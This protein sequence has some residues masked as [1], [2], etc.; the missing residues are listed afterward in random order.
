MLPLCSPCAVPCSPLVPLLPTGFFYLQTIFFFTYMIPSCGLLVFH[1]LGNGTGWVSD[2]RRRREE[3][4][5]SC[6]HPCASLVLF[7][8][9]PLCLLLPSGIFTY[10]I[11][12][13]GRLV[14]PLCRFIFSYSWE[15]EWGGV[16][17]PPGLRRALAREDVWPKLSLI[18]KP[19]L[20]RR[21]FARQAP[22]KRMQCDPSL[23]PS[24]PPTAGGRRQLKRNMI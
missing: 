23:R 5:T 24:V 16:R 1:I 22:T 21:G 7:L 19:I 15:W 6:C 10:M 4:K 8:V 14:L 11:P 9:R 12:S 17:R 13:F 20:H 18:T 2:G 3:I